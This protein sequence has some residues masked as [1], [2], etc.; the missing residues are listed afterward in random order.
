VAQPNRFQYT[1]L[2]GPVFVGAVA[3]TLAWLPSG[4]PQPLRDLPRPPARDYTVLPPFQPPVYDPA[5]LQWQ[6]RGQQP[7]RDLLAGRAETVEPFP[8]FD[9]AALS[10]L[11]YTPWL[12]P[13]ERRIAQG[14][15]LDPFPRPPVVYDP[16]GMQWWVPPQPFVRDLARAIVG[17]YHLDPFPLP[18]A[19]PAPVTPPPQSPGGGGRARPV[20]HILTLGYEAKL[21]ADW[22]LRGVEVHAHFRQTSVRRRVPTPV[23]FE[24]TPPSAVAPYVPTPP[25]PPVERLEPGQR[26][27]SLVR[28][29]LVMPA[30]RVMFSAHATAYVSMPQAELERLEQVPAWMLGAMWML[31]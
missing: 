29:L 15:V 4:N 21:H 8:Q 3:A 30:M 10:W 16:A 17:D 23:R 18:G 9:P 20:E 26:P 1:A 25:F 22:T 2:V 5:G 31:E 14:G 7:A 28:A 27:L 12:A 24:P 11:P 6:P 13:V 19:P